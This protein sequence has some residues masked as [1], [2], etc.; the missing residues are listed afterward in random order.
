M[1]R[2]TFAFAGLGLLPL[3]GPALGEPL[4]CDFAGYR[5][6]PGLTAQAAD[7]ALTVAWDGARPGEAVRLRLA[8]DAGKPLIRELGVRGAGGAWTPLATNVAPEFRVVT[9]LRRIT[10]QQ[11]APLRN[12]GR[13][14]TDETIDEEKWEAFWDAPL[15]VGGDPAK[16]PH[17]SGNPPAEGILHQPGL[18]RRPEEVRR[19]AA[20]FDLHGCEVRTN[21]AR[22][23]ISF[24]GV[25]LG[26]FSGRLQY[27]VYRG[28]NLI[29]QEVVVK[30]DER[31]V[32][33]KYDAGLAGFAL[34]PDAHMAWRDVTRAWQSY[35][36][37]GEPNAGPVPVQS[38]NRLIAAE[39][40]GGAI[41]VF[42]PPHTFFWAREINSNLGYSWYRKDGSQAFSF[43]VR[44]PES[45]ADQGQA[46]HGPDDYRD[47]FAL[48]SARPGTWQRMAVY[49]LADARPAREVNDAA[50]AYTRGD[51]YKALPGHKVMLAHVHAYF[52][53]RMH[54]QGVTVDTKPPDF[55]AVKAAG[56]NVF[57]PIDGGAAGEDGTP[58]AE[59][60]LGNLATIY[61]LAKR[62]SD[63]DF[64]VMPNTEVTEGELPDLVKA[65]GGHWDLHVPHPVLFA[66]GRAAGQPLVD[67]SPTFGAFYRLGSADDVM[68][69]MR[70]EGMIAFM[71]HP[72]SKGST[73]YPDAIKDTDRFRNEAFRG[74]GYRW[75]M[76]LNGSDRRLCDERCLTTLDDMNNWTADLPTPP[77]YIEA[78]SEFYQ[79][80]PG[81]DIYAN[82]PVNY[83]KLDSIP[84]PGDWRPIVEALRRG[85]YFVTSGE[86]LIPNYRIEGSGARRTIVADVEWTFPLDFVEVVWGDGRKTDR[87]IIPAT[88]LPAFGSKRFEI[89]FDV[90]GKKWVRF[91]AWDSAGNGAL[92]QPVKLGRR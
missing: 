60:Y 80:N 15:R 52:V 12:L 29:R 69:M 34:T 82:T 45:E 88:D 50:L 66:Q 41:A 43:G 10:G 54:E 53:R 55:D 71:P 73:G 65:L 76:G 35:A 49:I 38:N 25:T 67:R 83:L 37:G 51:H 6:L 28:T 31:S 11:L 77:K 74:V 30:T 32:A 72:R 42:P 26:P 56:V 7:D 19:A 75:G 5:P 58:S 92:V 61:A 90:R 79:Q 70:R 87:Q 14:I 85:E 48:V 68:E 36:F 4:D 1:I 21:G 16:N 62:H 8:V 91:A 17:A 2:K 84:A 44:Q 23:E 24:E 57:A 64:T 78:I 20:A 33:Y 81:D 27:S 63:R 39:T 18:P 46:G 3:A 13:E 40:G 22:L 89:P 47:N 9:G 59:T 86:V